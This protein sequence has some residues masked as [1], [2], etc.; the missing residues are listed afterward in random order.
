M[1]GLTIRPMFKSSLVLIPA[2]VINFS[3]GIAQTQPAL[4]IP[5]PDSQVKPLL[6]LRSEVL[7]TK[8]NNA[9]KQQ[10]RWRHL[11]ERKKMAVGLVDLA[12]PSDIAFASV[13]GEVMMYAASLPKLAILLASCQAIEEGKL[14]PSE[15]IQSD[16]KVMVSRSSNTAATRMID[17][18]GFRQ[19]ERVLRSPRY[20]FYDPEHGGGLWVGKRYART[21]R[22]YPEPMKGLSHAATV[23]QVCRFYYLLAFG[24]LVSEEQSRH[25]LEILENP[26]INH[27]FVHSLREIAPQAKLFR[28]SGSWRKWHSDSVLVWGPEWRRYILVGLIEDSKGEQILRELVS[29]VEK[30]LLAY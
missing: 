2:F 28:K 22:R 27:K 9:L 26:E 13:N 29:V 24:R 30:V 4:P 3:F 15:T 11:I 5:L 25:M 12:S 19:I 16:L 1:N 7:Q 6:Q 21:G 14:Q 8:L 20:R 10:P 17:N 18:L 23:N